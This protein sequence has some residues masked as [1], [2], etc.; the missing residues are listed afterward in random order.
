MAN[1]ID[2]SKVPGALVLV[3]E[4]PSPVPEVALFQCRILLSQMPSRS[5]TAGRTFLDDVDAA[6][7]AQGGPS[8]IAWE[9]GNTVARNGP[10]V[11]AMAAEFLL[12]DVELDALFEQASQIVV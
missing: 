3:N 10:L 6:I 2:Y 12:S 11:L 7:R 4:V 5:G 9:Y 1:E 8:L